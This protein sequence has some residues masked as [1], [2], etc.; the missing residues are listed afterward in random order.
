MRRLIVA[1][2]ITLLTL[3]AA[4][5]RRAST[6][7]CAFNN[8]CAEPLVCGPGNACRAQC[9]TSRDCHAGWECAVP[10]VTDAPESLT[11]P[12]RPTSFRTLESGLNRCV[13]PGAENRVRR[14]GEV[15]ALLPIL[16]PAT[17]RPIGVIE[18]VASAQQTARPVASA[19]PVTRS[20]G[21]VAAAVPATGTTLKI[22]GFEF[23]RGDK[24]YLWMRSAG[25]EWTNVGAGVL[26]SEPA[27]VQLK[28]KTIFVVARG[29]DD[30][31]WAVSCHSGACSDWFSLG[32]VIASAPSAILDPDGRIR[33]RATGTD[34]NSWAI[35]GDGKEW[36]GWMPE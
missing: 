9:M 25:G 20:T 24:N 1:T 8:D 3:P 19:V 6:A 10:R 35:V 15:Y 22:G 13:P 23:Q 7:Q 14:Q 32:G 12:G 33:V 36:S 16:D 11:G 34:G 2:A 17:G 27:A 30:A 28:D 26:A 5:Q 31:V 29:M 18:A 21:A 4:A